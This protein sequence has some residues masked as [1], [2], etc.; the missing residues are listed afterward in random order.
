[1][2]FVRLVSN[3]S[4]KSE[5][6][7]LTICLRRKHN[8]DPDNLHKSCLRYIISSENLKFKR[9]LAAECGNSE[10]TTFEQDLGGLGNEDA[11][12]RNHPLL[13]AFCL[14]MAMFARDPLDE[15][16]WQMAKIENLE[17]ASL[18]GSVQSSQQKR[19]YVPALQSVSVRDNNEIRGSAHRHLV[20][21]FK[22]SYVLHIPRSPFKDSRPIFFAFFA[23]WH[24]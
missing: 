10:R 24:S 15:Q 12:F 6:Y 16:M 14:H 18:V 13:L 7:S 2:I 8:T 17:H 5:L 22:F 11:N 23:R 20:H 4:T 1:M 3:S 9:L 21:I 19:W